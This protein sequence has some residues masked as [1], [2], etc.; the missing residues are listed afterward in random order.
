MALYNFLVFIWL[1]TVTCRVGI[2]IQ[3]YP[4]PVRKAD[5]HTLVRA[6]LEDISLNCSIT[7]VSNQHYPQ[8]IQRNIYLISQSMLRV[9]LLVWSSKSFHVYET[10]ASHNR[11]PCLWSQS[12]I[13]EGTLTIIQGQ[14]MNGLVSSLEPHTELLWT[15]I[16]TR[17]TFILQTK[18]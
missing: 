16:Q 6:S 9:E 8:R 1:C 15:N 13:F 2:S 4:A 5:V 14:E 11:K 12:H 10:L 7:A 3:P 17:Y 18:Q